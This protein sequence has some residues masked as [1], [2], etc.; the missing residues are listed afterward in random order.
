MI[1]KFKIIIHKINKKKIDMILIQIFKIKEFRLKTENLRKKDNKYLNH[2]VKI[3]VE[4]LIMRTINKIYKKK[5][6]F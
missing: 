5:Q 3:R 1:T 2:V 4:K 6:K